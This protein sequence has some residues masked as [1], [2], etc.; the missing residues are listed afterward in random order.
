MGKIDEKISSLTEYVNVVKKY[1]LRN[2]YF[3]GENQKYSNICSCLVRDYFPKEN[4]VGLIHTYS[5]LL[6]GYYQ[7]IGYE[8]N[9][10]QEENFLA[11]SQHHGLKTNLI[12]FTTAPLVAL[13]F[14]CERKMYDVNSGYVYILNEKETIDASGFL[15][16]FSIKDHT[17]YNVFSRLFYNQPDVVT[18]FKNLFEGYPDVLTDKYPYNLVRNMIEQIKSY[19]Y[20][21]KSN[22]YLREREQCEKSLDG[23][24]K[25][26]QIIQSYLPDFNVLGGM[27]LVEYIALL[28]MFFD[29]LRSCQLNIP[30]NMPF[31]TIPY[32]M[33]K[34]PLKFDRIKNQCGVFLYQ[35]FVDY[36]I[37]CGKCRG[38][39]IQKIIPSM[40]IQIENQKEIMNELDLVGINKR[41][42]YGDFDN[43]A[44]Y[45]NMK[46]MGNMYAQ[47]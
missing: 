20:F 44:Q 24:L 12:D 16:E 22:S 2:Q 31:P 33:Y 9:K 19:P 14:A 36:E 39:M 43:T 27:R 17:F 46:F 25:I 34:T 37:E 26:P 8:L 47:D 21:E 18:S 13:Y 42:I 11:F 23:F 10:M 45:I 30:S 5:K 38:L 6:R 41:Y 29:D 15:Q 32:F 40:T 7:E 28:L 3:R 4:G 35:G 1:D